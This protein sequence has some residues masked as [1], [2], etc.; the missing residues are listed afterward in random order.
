MANKVGELI[1]RMEAEEG[2]EVGEGA[3]T[4]RMATASIVELI[5]NDMVEAPKV[6]RR[7]KKL[8]NI[9]GK[10]SDSAITQDLITALKPVLT[11]WLDKQDVH[12]TGGTKAQ[13]SVKTFARTR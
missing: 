4:G 8:V 11:L 1:E 7:L 6:M 9:E 2:Y 12:V 13:L 3:A 10:V 5:A